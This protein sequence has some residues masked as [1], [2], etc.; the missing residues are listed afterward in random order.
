M[1]VFLDENFPLGL[2]RRL[3][4]AGLQAEHVITIGW[5]GAPDARIRGRLVEADLLF[6]TQDD[7]FFFSKGPLAII[8]VSR[9]KQSRP[10]HERID[11]WQSAVEY[12]V[13]NPPTDRRFDLLDNGQLVPWAEDSPSVWT[14]KAPPQ[15][16]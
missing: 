15:K 16:S 2:E 9:V 12:L 13:A 8:V 11:L 3:K 6:L 4:N 1:K 14:R 5:R 10:L 7:D